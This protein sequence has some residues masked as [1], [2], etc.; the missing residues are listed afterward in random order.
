MLIFALSC[1][2]AF[3]QIYIAQTAGSVTCSVWGVQTAVTVATWNSTNTTN[4]IGRICGTLAAS[5]GASGY[6]TFNGTGETLTFD[7]G[8]VM[9]APYWGGNGAISSSQASTLIDGGTNGS[10]VA[11]A[12]GTALANQI[13]ATTGVMVSGA[14]S[15]VRNLA[16]SNLYVHT[17]NLAD[18]ADGTQNARGAIYCSA[19][20]NCLIHNNV[21]HDTGTCIRMGYSTN[22]G[23]QAY[24]NTCYNINWGVIVG[25]NSGSSSLTGLVAIYGNIIHDF[26]IWDQTDNFNHH[27]GI[28]LFATNTGSSLVGSYVYN[29]YIYGDPGVYANTFL[30]VS[31]FPSTC[32]GN[33]MFNNVLNNTS[34]T[35]N[36][37]PANGL[38]QN[39]CAGDF[40]TNNT[41]IG[42]TQSSTNPIN[43]SN[44]GASINPGTST[45]LVNNVFEL[46]RNGWGMGS[47]ASI[48]ASDYNDYYNNAALAWD[49][50]NNAYTTLTALQGCHTN[51]CPTGTHDT[52]SIV[53]NPNLSSSFVPN[54][55]SPLIGA[56]ENF[57]STC[58]GQPNPGLGA[59][60]LDKASNARPTSGNWDIGAFQFQAITGS[61]STLN[62]GTK[63]N[64]GSAFQ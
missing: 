48:A 40:F 53:G 21:I 6:I 22:V 56:G 46:F 15:E 35:T 42:I 36:D 38:H 16:I 31:N 45:T 2:V 55:G 62:S 25:D 8:A 13:S 5:A 17:V 14:S 61:G 51:G 41:V 27:D 1:P 64:S 11:T 32:G 59:M 29:N 60:C 52:N 47:G 43:A 9:T 19:A 18:T 33:Y 3:S 20:N 7:T 49:S 50:A 26:L 34:G 57:F 10:I 28:Y 12:N 30:F 63:T 58:S 44:P 23:F 37:T 24:N 4:S 54:T 39:W